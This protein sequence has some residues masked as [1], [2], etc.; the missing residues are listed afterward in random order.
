MNQKYSIETAKQIFK[1]EGCEL[2]ETKYLNCNIPMKYKCK[3]GNISKISLCSFKNGTRCRKC[4]I[5]R[6]KYT[7]QE[8]YDYFREKGCELLSKEYAGSKKYLEYRCACGNVAKIEFRIFKSGHLCKKCSGK[9][10]VKTMHKRYNG[11]LYSQTKKFKKQKEKTCLKKYGVKNPLQNEEIKKNREKT[12]MKKYGVKNVCQTKSHQ[13]AVAKTLKEKYGVEYSSQIP[14]FG[15]KV[16]A[17]MMKKYGVPSGVYLISPCSKESQKL[18]FEIHKKLSKNIAKKNHFGKLNAEFVACLEGQYFK[19]D[20]VNT[21]L[22]RVIEYNGYNFHPKP[23]QNENEIGW[24]SFHP[25]KTVK[26]ARKYEKKKYL[27][28][29]KRGYKIL[30]VWDYEFK[31]NPKQLVQKCIDFLL[32]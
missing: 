20:F 32:S 16:K 6:S 30:T 10:M 26:D 14:G 27:T 5:E 29:E 11:K 8:V 4:C 9:R 24:C 25:N 2:L 1:D 7:Y 18:F 3:C 19:Y 22:K 15:D 31:K 13:N 23:E 17:T 28:L 12:C 21:K